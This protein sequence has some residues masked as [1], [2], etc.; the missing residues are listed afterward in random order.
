MRASRFV[1]LCL[2]YSGVIL[3]AQYALVYRFGVG[4]VALA[5]LVTGLAVLA[6]GLYR[7]HRDDPTPTRY[8]PLAYGLGALV[9]LLTLIFVGQL[10]LVYDLPPAAAGGPP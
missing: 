10:L 2:V 1:T 4:L 6:A 5:Q 3:T 7:F 8:G 9:A